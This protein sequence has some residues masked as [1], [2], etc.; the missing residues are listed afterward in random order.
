M[1]SDPQATNRAAAE[2]ARIRKILISDPSLVLDD[3]ELMR[4]L[5]G[6][7]QPK[8]R[9]VVDLRGVLVERLEQRLGKLEQAHKTVIA[10]A[11]D[12]LAGVSQI[13]RTIL[14]LLD[15]NDFAGA[16]EEI[17]IELPDNLALDETRLCFESDVGDVNGPAFG[18]GLP[19]E[20]EKSI[21]AL[22]S[23]ALENYL[24]L[25]RDVEEE[26]IVLRAAPAERTLIF[27]DAAALVRSEALVSLDIGGAPALLAMG[28]EDPDR[29]TPDHGDDLLIFLGGVVERVLRRWLHNA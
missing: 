16:L 5:V 14:S 3:A 21:V 18:L 8:A 7:I 27:G 10:A 29:F 12:N 2:A 15:R 26:P 11:Y 23:G 13:H 22:P 24:R 25:G 17:L 1:S 4:A 9:N 28:S 19:Q 6:A 20:V